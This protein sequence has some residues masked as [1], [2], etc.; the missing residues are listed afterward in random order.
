MSLADK[1]LLEAL[2]HSL[3]ANLVWYSDVLG[4]WRRA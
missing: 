2:Y 1:E 3:P 4:A